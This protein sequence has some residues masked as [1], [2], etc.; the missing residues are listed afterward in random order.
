MAKINM[1]ILDLELN[2]RNNTKSNKNLTADSIN[3]IADIVGFDTKYMCE[4]FNTAIGYSID[5]SD[6]DLIKEMIA[7]ARTKEGRSARCKKYDMETCDVIQKWFNSF[8]TL[9]EHNGASINE[10]KSQTVKMHKKTDYVILKKRMYEVHPYIEAVA[11]RCFFAPTN[12]FVDQE[13]LLTEY[14]KIVFLEYITLRKDLTQQQICGIYW[15]FVAAREGQE[16]QECLDQLHQMNES[17]KRILVESAFRRAE[18]DRAL[19]EDDEYVNIVKAIAKIEGGEGKLQDK[20]KVKPLMKQLLNVMDQKA[21]NILQEGDFKKTSL[22]D[23]VKYQ[24]EVEASVSAEQFDKS[25][26]LLLKARDMYD[27]LVYK[28]IIEPL[29][30]DNITIIELEYLSRFGEDMF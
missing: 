2:Q 22:V 4:N 24:A 21:E 26:D 12:Y 5:E 18:F 15:C 10:I 1:K 25:V 30:D 9:A 3:E 8:L 20:K 13:D 6:T 7:L 27:S 29:D 28:R 17:E 11:E 19:S 23:D 16:R 14:D